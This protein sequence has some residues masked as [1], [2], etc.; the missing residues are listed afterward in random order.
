[1]NAT[2]ITIFTFSIALAIGIFIGKL[3]FT[4]RSLSEKTGLEEKLNGFSF[5]ID[6]LK[7]QLQKTHDEK[8]AIRTEKDSLVVQL[9]KKEVDFDNLWVA[10]RNKNR[11]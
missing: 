2:L 7:Q 9:T 10:T 4:A 3:L 5:Q 8:E 1:M 6:G 11:K